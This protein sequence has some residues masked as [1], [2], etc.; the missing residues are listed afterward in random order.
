MCGPVGPNPTLQ[1]NL[2]A[3]GDG[4]NPSF[5]NPSTSVRRNESKNRPP[6]TSHFGSNI[7][8]LK[9]DEDDS[10]FNDRNA[11]WNGNSTQYGGDNNGR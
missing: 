11:F 7:H 4:P 10:R 5:S 8:T 1:N 6:T 3:R 2:A 9:H